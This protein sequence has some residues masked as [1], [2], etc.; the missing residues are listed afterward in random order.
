MRLVSGTVEDDDGLPVGERESL[1][2]GRDPHV[3]ELVRTVNGLPYRKLD[4]IPPDHGQLAAWR[5]I[6]RNH[7]VQNLPGAASRHRDASE[8]AS[9][10]RREQP[11]RIVAAFEKREL[12]GQR[13]AEQPGVRDVER[14]RFRTAASRH[15][16]PVPVA[17]PG[18]TVD[19]GFPVR[20]EP[21]GGHG[22]GPE[23]DW[24]EL[25]RRGAGA[26]RDAAGEIHTAG[27]ATA[28]TTRSDG[29]Y[30][31]AEVPA[32][33]NRVRRAVRRCAV[34]PAPLQGGVQVR[35]TLPTL[36]GILGEALLHDAVDTGG[37]ARPHRRQ[38]RRIVRQD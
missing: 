21:G 1:P 24:N 20:G 27:A 13:Y 3:V 9:A 10:W 16:Q 17:A 33:V 28:A 37:N 6:R 2:I 22:S 14:Q 12:P 7:V 29:G 4:S 31:A 11:Q 23:R 32:F 35:S 19:D 30:A 25:R 26:G 36:V 38:R 34:F 8:R 15:E 5:P 18:C